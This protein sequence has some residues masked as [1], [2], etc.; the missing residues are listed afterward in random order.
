LEA[1]GYLLVYLIKGKLP[2]QG[3]KTDK[4]RTQKYEAIMNKKLTTTVSELCRNLP[5]CFSSYLD[6]VRI[7]KFEQKPDYAYLRGLFRNL[8]NLKGYVMDYKY[9]WVAWLG[10]CW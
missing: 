3:L 9:D 8:F 1:I 4:L 10:A 2:W 7:L 5:S 6:V